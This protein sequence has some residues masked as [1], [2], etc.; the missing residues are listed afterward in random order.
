VCVPD[1]AKAVQFYLAGDRKRF[2]AYF[3]TDHRQDRDRHRFM[4]DFEGLRDALCVVGFAEVTQRE[5]Q[6]GSTP[7]LDQLD[8]RSDET[9]YVEAVRPKIRTSS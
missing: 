4:Y 6:I 5:F 3:F 2:L 9:L 8:N 7:D 1:L